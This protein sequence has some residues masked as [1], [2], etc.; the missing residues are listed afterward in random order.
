MNPTREWAIEELRRMVLEALGDCDAE[1]WLFGSC[2]QDSSAALRYRYRHPARGELPTGFFG[3]L[4]AEEHLASHAA[5]LRRWLA[6]LRQRRRQL[7]GCQA[8]GP[9]FLAD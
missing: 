6:A 4:N 8:S 2:A 5:L 3:E 7:T 9:K 1:V